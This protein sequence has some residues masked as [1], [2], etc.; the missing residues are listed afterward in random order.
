[1]SE[2]IEERK[3]SPPESLLSGYAPPPGGY[4]ELVDSSGQLR[5]TWRLF[6]AGLV[7]LGQTGVS[8][9][10]E[11]ARRLLRENGLLPS[12]PGATLGSERHWEVDPLPLLI[13]K[14]EWDP[15]AAGI[16][17]RARVLDKLLADIYGP[18]T[19]L[20]AGVVPPELI[21]GQR[22]FLPACH[23]YPL[24]H[25]FFLHLYAADLARDASGQWTVL[26]DFTQAPVGP[27][28]ALENRL[29]ISR[30]LPSDFHSLHVQRLAGS[31]ITLRETL[32]ALAAQRPENPRVVLLSPGPRSSTYFEDTYLARYLGY[33]L[34]EG[35]D[36]TVRGTSVYLKTLGGLL[37]V[38]VILRRMAD[39]DCDPLELRYDSLHG[40]AGLVQ[41]VRTGQ[42]A[43]ANGLGSGVVEAPALMAFLPEICRRL[44]GEELRLPSAPTWWC[45]READ[46]QYVQSHFDELVIGPA[47]SPPRTGMPSPCLRSTLANATN[48]W[49]TCVAIDRP[50]ARGQAYGDRRRR[51]GTTAPFNPGKFACAFSASFRAAALTT[52]CQAAWPGQLPCRQGRATA[53]VC[54]IRTFGSFQTV[55]CRRLP[56]CALSP[57]Q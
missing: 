20:R 48:S 16:E 42:V 22:G 12:G 51:F 28:F 53:R 40:V 35:G 21:F 43:V 34:V 6:A 54:A 57:P 29:V 55:P 26:A 19:L 38:D 3:F 10:F 24:P 41:A 25:N 47:V 49:K 39:D 18:Q 5:E 14:S 56:F 32:Q 33:T 31:F 44:L 1:M 27:G 37:P 30:T 45:G 15:L 11:Q 9:R 36:L 23:G 13:S 46:W 2:T 8:Q 4:D 17:Q 52:S 50:I 7:A